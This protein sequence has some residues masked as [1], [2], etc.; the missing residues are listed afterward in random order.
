MDGIPRDE[1]VVAALPSGS[2]SL[3]Y[4]LRCRSSRPPEYS[5]LARHQNNIYSTDQGIIKYDLNQSYYTNA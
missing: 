3:P 4:I 2:A 1:M 5:S